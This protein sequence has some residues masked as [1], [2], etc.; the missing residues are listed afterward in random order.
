MLSETQR[1]LR[2]RLGGLA[3]ASQ[4][5]PCDYTAAA[6]DAFLA[7]FAAE[8]DPE[9]VLPEAERTRRA[10]AARKLYFTRLALKSSRARQ[11]RAGR[12]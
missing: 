6:R 2:A 4:R 12:G 3:L 8:V 11:R 5:D 10:E 1:S 7:R 9:G